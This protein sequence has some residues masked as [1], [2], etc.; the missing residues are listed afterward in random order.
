MC[1][2]TFVNSQSEIFITSNRDE[3]ITRPKAIEPKLYKHNQY[4]IFY[5]KDA[6]AGGTW[7][8]HTKNS[9]LVLLNGAFKK[10]IIKNNYAKSRGLILLDIIQT[11]DILE[12]FNTIKLNNIEPFTLICYQNNNLYEL[13]WNGR[14]KFL[15]KLNTNQNYI[16]SSVTLYNAKARNKRKKYFEKFINSE[17]LS[18]ETILKFHKEN[19]IK[20]C[21]EAKTVAAK[22]KIETVSTTQCIIQK[23][24]AMKYYT[25]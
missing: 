16:W 21:L 23:N 15:K 8:A 9:C 7:I 5:P 25:Y 6:K 14:K 12:T 22:H 1:T 20:N 11:N 10:H 4:K 24:I 2:V 19:H 13:I 3:Q 18:E 17:E